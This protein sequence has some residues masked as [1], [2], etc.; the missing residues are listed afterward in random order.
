MYTGVFVCVCVCVRVCACVSVCVGV[1]VCA[2]THARLLY[3]VLLQPVSIHSSS[4]SCFVQK[5]SFSANRKKVIKLVRLVTALIMYRVWR[6][7][8]EIRE[9]VGGPDRGS[10]PGCSSSDPGVGWVLVRSR[11]REERGACGSRWGSTLRGE[12]G[13]HTDPDR[14]W[15]PQGGGSWGSRGEV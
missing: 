1:R 6:V 10:N 15:N 7:R 11:S 14:G 2:C 3:I 5:R 4:C 12:E 8:L 13:G 9:K